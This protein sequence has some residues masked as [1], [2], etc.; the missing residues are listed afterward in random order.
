[1]LDPWDLSVDIRNQQ[2]AAAGVAHGTASLHCPDCG[3]RWDRS[4]TDRC[5]TC[6]L[7]SDDLRA[8]LERRTA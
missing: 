3:A 6:G 4:L 5:A 2:I 8:R 7:T 1:M